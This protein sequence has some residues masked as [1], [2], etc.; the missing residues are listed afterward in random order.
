L[1]QKPNMSAMNRMRESGRL[2]PSSAWVLAAAYLYAGKPEVAQELIAGRQIGLTD[3]Y[4]SAGYTYGSGLRDMAFT[5][6][7]LDMLKKDTEAFRLMEKMAG[8]LKGN[9]Y[10]T[11]TTSFCLCAIARYTGKRAGN[12][13]SFDYMLNESKNETVKTA[14]SIYIVDLEENTDNSGN[15][16]LKNKS[17]DARLFMNIT[18]T[19]QPVQGLETEQSSGL[20]LSI[21]YKTDNGNILDVGSIKQGTDFI[22]EVTVEHPGVFFDYT[23]MALS[24][25]FPSGWEIINTRV[26]DVNSGLKED[27]FDYRDIR[28]DRV[29]TFFSLLRYNKKT[30]RIRLNAAYAGKYYLPSVSCEAMYETNIHANSKG[31]WVEVVR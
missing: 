1:A 13:I 22:A 20:K 12:G 21:V 23:D 14:K 19:G 6:E 28:D 7:V 27:I 26:Q 8:E 17:P 4:I 25:V 10:S 31:R 30:F 29:Y 3:N 2:S 11:Q 16:Q 24:Q 9:Y 5:L 15:I 18:L